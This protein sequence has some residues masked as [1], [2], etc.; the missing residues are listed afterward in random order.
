MSVIREFE[1]ETIKIDGGTQVRCR[2]DEGLVK[3]Y[4]D[5]LDDMPPIILF[6]DGSDY[7]LADGFHRVHAH[8]RGGRKMIQATVRMGTLRDA[9][10]YSFRVN[11]T[12]G[13][14]LST[15]DKVKVIRTILADAE[16]KQW[17][18]STIAAKTGF[19]RTFIVKHRKV[20]QPSSCSRLQ[21]SNLTKQQSVAIPT[22][23]AVSPENKKRVEDITAAGG[24]PRI[25][26]KHGKT[27]VMDVANIG[28]KPVSEEPEPWDDAS[29][30]SVQSESVEVETVEAEPEGPK[31]PWHDFEATMR[32]D[33]STLRSVAASISK[34]LEFDSSTKQI[35]SKWSHDYSYVTTIKG[36]YE[37]IRM[38]DGGIPVEASS[39]APGYVTARRKEI[40]ERSKVA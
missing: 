39:G 35:K 1:I 29:S 8:L 6:H 9:I 23:P 2:I 33:I 10:E 31:A 13:K 22:S 24:T 32:R 36:I 14:P 30:Q 15:E 38:L 21:D 3:E 27:S 16:W 25:I 18:D 28:K 19:S 40:M 4:A 34:N 5:C 26:N 12:H 20:D 7:W 37:Y 17:N 11:S